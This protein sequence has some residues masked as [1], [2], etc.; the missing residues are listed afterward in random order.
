MHELQTTLQSVLVGDGGITI[1]TITTQPQHCQIAAHFTTIVAACLTCA[2]SSPS[3]HG[4]LAE[5]SLDTMRSRSPSAFLQ[6][7]K[8]FLR[9]ARLKIYFQAIIQHV[10]SLHRFGAS[11]VHA[12]NTPN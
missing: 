12:L 2:T 10:R 7:V 4:R 5:P 11:W 8:L 9:L 6:L 1:D 3:M